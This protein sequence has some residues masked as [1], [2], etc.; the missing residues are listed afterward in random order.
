MVSPHAALATIKTL[1]I[2][3]ILGDLAPLFAGSF[4]AANTLTTINL[5]TVAADNSGT[6]FGLA[7]Q[8]FTLITFTE[9]GVKRTIKT[10]AELAAAGLPLTDFNIRI[11]L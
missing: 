2:K 7:G 4:I 3:G 5:L 1:N 8:A 6:P 11:P 9:S 10:P